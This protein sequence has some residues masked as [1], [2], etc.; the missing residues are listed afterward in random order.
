MKNYF[1]LLTALGALLSSCNKDDEPTDPVI[2]DSSPTPTDN[3]S[4]TFRNLNFTA[5]YSYFSTDGSM[6]IPVDSNEAKL[7]TASID[8]SFI[9]ANEIHAVGFMDPIV[10]SQNIWDSDEYFTLWL[11]GAVETRYFITS[12]EKVHFDSAQAD[13]NKISVYL[14]DSSVTSAPHNIYPVGSSVGIIEP[15]TYAEPVERGDVFGFENTSTGKLGLIYIHEEQRFLWPTN[16]TGTSN[17]TVI[18]IIREH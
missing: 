11:D 8:I 5:T 13:Q 1:I 10:Q 15:S 9:Q 18:D 4:L 6:T 14:S 16:N 12:L 2:E 17:E 7:E 3:S